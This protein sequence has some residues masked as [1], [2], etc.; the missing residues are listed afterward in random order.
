MEDPKKPAKYL[1]LVQ[2]IKEKI[3]TGVYISG[4]KIESENQMVKEYGYSRQTIR[5]AL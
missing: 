1:R 2:D 5:Q 4:D 3:S